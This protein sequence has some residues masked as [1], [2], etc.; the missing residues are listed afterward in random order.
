M[1]KI[2][3][4]CALVVA[5]A[6]LV[7][8]FT[9]CGKKEEEETTSPTESTSNF[10]AFEPTLTIS[11]DGAVVAY[12]DARFQQLS[13]PE[14][15]E[16]NYDYEY[17]KEHYDFVDMNF[18]KVPDISIAAYKDGK[19]I[20][21]YCWLYDSI[22]NTYVYSEELSALNNITVDAENKQ[23]LSTV[24]SGKKEVVKVYSW[25]EGKLTEQKT[26]GENNETVP[27]EVSETIKNNSTVGA[28]KKPAANGT[29][30]PNAT[31]PSGGNKPAGTTKP[32]SGVTLVEGNFDE[33]WY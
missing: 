26:Y 24:Y 28:D 10:E 4:C 17:A 7:T 15:Y 22:T 1:K 16:K 13:F 14:G 3:T 2:I 25:V 6:L 8:A 18:D 23:I 27:P 11:K 21:Y 12:G 30:K 5:L 19:N 33:G 31:K 9:A 32:S 29:T 20:G